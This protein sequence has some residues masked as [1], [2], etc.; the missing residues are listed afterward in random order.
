MAT[1]HKKLK[2]GISY[3]LNGWKYIS[4]KGTPTECGYA[5]GFFVAEQ[6][7]QIKEMLIFLC[8]EDYGYEWQFFIDAGVK[9]LKTTIK[10]K[11]AE[12]YEE[13]EGIVEGIN[14]ANV[15][16]KTDIDEIL[17]WNN[18]FLLTESWFANREGED[19]K[20]AASHHGEGG[21]RSRR[22][23]TGIGTGSSERCSAFIATGKD[24]TSDGKIVCAHNNF[25][26]FVDG[27]WARNVVDI[28]CD[29][30]NR[31]LYMGFVG[32]IWSG[33]DFWVTSAGILGTETTIGGFLP[34]ENNYPISCRLRKAMQ[35]GNTMDEYI[36]TLL[37]GNSGDYANS[38]M[39]G[40]IN[41]NEI[42]VFELG[43]KYHDIKRTKNGFFIGHNAAYNPQIRNLECGNSG[44][45]DI[46]RHNCSRRVTL[47]DLIDKNKGKINID[48][49][50]LI[51]SNHFDPYLEK[52]NHPCSRTICAHYN[53]SPRKYMSQEY[54]PLPWQPRG[55]MDGNI[56][57]STLAE[58]MSFELK[59]GSSCDVPFD[60]DEHFKL[61]PQW[62]QYKPY[63]FSRP[64]QPYTLFTITD[65]HHKKSMKS[66]MYKTKHTNYSSINHNKTR[67]IKRK[68]K[69]ENE[70]EHIV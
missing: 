25:S 43:L 33:T 37:D 26:N 5:H 22:S 49:A 50:K 68:E 27:Q 20:K 47:N 69:R 60:A 38:Y 53:K 54:R 57:D 62:I 8:L 48:V 21:S 65:N 2:N 40:D 15:G 10:E 13:M 59:Y 41:T 45:N 36:E 4:V 61:H 11:F 31:I 58:K 52:D 55:S 39:F 17:A 16:V 42:M 9:L 23:G 12:Y 3:D 46:R 18:Y 67:K 70:E 51:L 66:R 7:K 1:N 19:G 35:Y 44:Y 56:I 24:Y 29:K 28:K 64:N 30:G 34:F 63:I 32:W 6:F 14:A